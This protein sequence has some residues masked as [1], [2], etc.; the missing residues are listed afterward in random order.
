MG[1][2]KEKAIEYYNDS[3]EEGLSNCCGAIIYMQ[4]ICADCKEHCE[5]QE[6][7]KKVKMSS[8]TVKIPMEVYHDIDRLLKDNVL[9]GDVRVTM[10]NKLTEY[11]VEGFKREKR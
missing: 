8:Y 2:F 11:I 3:I 5:P 4:D 9:R 6:E 1:H 10:G 7:D